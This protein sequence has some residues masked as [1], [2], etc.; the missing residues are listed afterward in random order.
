[1][2]EKAVSPQEGW[3][4]LA[5]DIKVFAVERH[6]FPEDFVPFHS[7][8]VWSAIVATRICAESC[9]CLRSA[10]V[11]GTG[12][13]SM[14]QVCVLRSCMLKLDDQTFL[15]RVSQPTSTLPLRA[16]AETVECASRTVEDGGRERLWSVCAT[17][18]CLSRP[19]T[20]LSRRTK[21]PSSPNCRQHCMWELGRRGR[22]N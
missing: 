21:P 19:N 13:D 11:A 7:L 6:G 20:F 1:M 15:Q 10:T 9:D 12:R 22:W 18:A 3:L 4:T 5:Q 8:S 17:K 2:A 16:T 14:F